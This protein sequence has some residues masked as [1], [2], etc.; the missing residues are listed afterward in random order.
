MPTEG[1]SVVAMGSGPLLRQIRLGMIR[2]CARPCVQNIIT[3]PATPHRT[4]P[5]DAVPPGSPPPP[6]RRA[7]STVMGETRGK[8]SIVEAK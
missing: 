8:K 7:L 4:A 5:S 1:Q 6:A 3:L 2:G